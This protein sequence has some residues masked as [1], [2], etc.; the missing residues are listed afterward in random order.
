MDHKVKMGLTVV[1]V[2][3]MLL[4]TER[5]YLVPLRVLAYVHVFGSND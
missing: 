4:M 5:H 2:I 1:D 3:F